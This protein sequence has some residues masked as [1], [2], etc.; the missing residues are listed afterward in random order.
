M[1]RAA[2]TEL[3]ARIQLV[4]AELSALHLDL[5][6]YGDVDAADAVK[7]ANRELELVVRQGLFTARGQEL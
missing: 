2:N 3:F 5:R 6:S 7:R 1:G 4:A